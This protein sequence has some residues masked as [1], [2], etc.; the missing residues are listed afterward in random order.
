LYLR[1]TKIFSQYIIFIIFVS[2]SLIQAQVDTLWTKTFGGSD[3]DVGNSVQQ[4]IDEGYVIIGYTYSFGAGDRD[5][6]LVKI[7]ADGDTLWTKTFGGS[8]Y[9][10]GYSVQQ[11]T[12][13]GFII[14]GRTDSFGAGW[15]DVCLIKTNASGDTLWT[16]TIGGSGDDE[17]RSVQ[18]TM[19]EGFIITGRTGSFGTGGD[20]WLIK[21]NADGDTLW[22]KTFGG[23][24][25]DYGSAVQQ[26]PDGGYVIIGYT[27]SFGAGD[28]DN[29]L[30]KT[31]ADGDTV[32]TKTF[33]GSGID[34]GYSVQQTSDGGY[35]IT[36]HSGSF[37]T[38]GD[39]WLIKTNASGDTL[40]TKTLG[41]SNSDWSQSGQ[42][43]EDEGYIIAGNIY[44]LGVG[45][46][47]IWLIKTDAVGDTL[48][49]KTLGGS[50]DDYGSAVQQTKGDEY[51]ITGYTYSFGAGRSD[52]WL[53]KT[54]SE[55][56]KVIQNDDI[57][58]SDYVL[59]QN[60]PNPF[61]P[62]TTIEFALPKIERVT[63]KVFNVL[64]QQVAT[65]LSGKLNPG[66]HK[67]DWRANNLPSGIYY[68]RM[69]AGQFEQV[70]KMI[71][72]R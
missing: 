5:I 26:T 11:T 40:W 58:I 16:K 31:N 6:W 59:T 47:D 48:W 51:I 72:L 38:G 7:N 12:D 18:Q 49:T 35:I 27:S 42:Q 69:Q 45:D 10:E 23:R 55:I 30:I 36:G 24:D 67:Y 61:N 56:N 65:L 39:I 52:V 70:R 33:G 2:I 41:G 25:G 44:S 9:E 54:T 64:G 19:D 22:T 71:L 28:Y 57:I 14:T 37:G 29:W 43:T 8:H 3:Y 17:G 46:Q 13:E 21:T 53:I 63:L 50:G 32:W 62:S 4:T 68:C 1:Q 20:V 34:Y 66:V 15:F 60:Y